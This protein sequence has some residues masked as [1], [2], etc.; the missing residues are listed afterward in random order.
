[1]DNEAI[2]LTP[3]PIN[4]IERG[5]VELVHTWNLQVY[6]LISL[7]DTLGRYLQDTKREINPATKPVIYNLVLP[8]KYAWAMVIHYRK[9]KIK[10]GGSGT[11]L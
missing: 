8:V 7:V 10:P 5:E 3:T 6:L 1:M 2:L 11:G 4:L 9:I